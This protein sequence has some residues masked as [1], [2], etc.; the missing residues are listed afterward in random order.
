MVQLQ[1]DP[2]KSPTRLVTLVA[3]SVHNSTST[4][5]HDQVGIVQ[6]RITDGWLSSPPLEAKSGLA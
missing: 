5:G 3:A 1:L 4:P 2:D 6:K